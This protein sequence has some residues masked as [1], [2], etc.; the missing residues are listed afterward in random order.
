MFKCLENSC[1]VVVNETQAQ[2]H[3]VLLGS[4]RC[5]HCLKIFM[6]FQT[7][8]YGGSLKRAKMNEEKRHSAKLTNFMF[9]LFII[10]NFSVSKFA[11][12][13]IN[14]FS[15]V[16]IMECFSTV[17]NYGIKREHI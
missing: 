17:R 10:S 4:A 1:D 7:A 11:N 3:R 16:N 15:I 8:T 2:R 14:R 6:G 9:S 12:V 5:D 13:S